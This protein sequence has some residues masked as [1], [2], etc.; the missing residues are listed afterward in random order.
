LIK[1]LVIK[2]EEVTGLKAWTSER[3]ESLTRLA[4]EDDLELLAEPPT[5]LDVLVQKLSLK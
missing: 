3:L 5:D 4:K 2:A 1:D